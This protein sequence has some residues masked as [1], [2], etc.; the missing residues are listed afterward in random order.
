MIETILSITSGNE[1]CTL[2][3]LSLL[4][5]TLL[6]LGSEWFFLLLIEQQQ[7]IPL[8]NIIIVATVGN[9]LGGCSNYLIG[10]LGS[11]FFIRKIL[12]IG[13]KEEERAKNIYYKYGNISLLFAWVPIIGDPL[14]LIAG[15]FKSSFT[16]F[17]TAVASG[18]FLR[19]L[20]IALLAKEIL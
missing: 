3:L 4:A 14:C 11:N 20:V 9:Y 8:T 17:S 13:Q 18:K 2:F 19:Y 15:L 16:I 12:R 6:P 10:Y 7:Q 5:A 1:L